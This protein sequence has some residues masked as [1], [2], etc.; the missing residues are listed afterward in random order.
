VILQTPENGILPEGTSGSIRLS[1]SIVG[2]EYWVTR[3]SALFTSEI[4]GTGS[5]LDLGNYYPSGSY[6]VNSRTQHNCSLVQGTVNFTT[7]TGGNTGAGK[8]VANVSFGTPASSFPANHVNVKLYKKEIDINNNEVIIY[9]AQ[10]TLGT[11]GQAEFLN[12]EPGDY[13]MGSFILYP[14][15]YN[16]AEHVYYQTAV[17]HEE[18]ISI[19]VFEETVFIANLHHVLLTESQGS[20]TM[21][22]IVGENNNAKSLNPKKDMVVV[23]KNADIDEIIGVSVTNEEGQYYFEDVPVNA[24][25]QAFVTSF[26]HQN[27]TAFE[28]ETDSYQTYNVN[29]IVSGTSVYPDYTTMIEDVQIQNIE[30]SVFPNPA[31]D[32][33]NINCDIEK[34]I[35]Q[36]FDISG[37]LVKTELAFSNSEINISE[38]VSGTYL[39]ILSAEN[40]KTGIQKFVKE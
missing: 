18:A 31:N 20:N 29:F 37:K 36:I 30:F 21:Q 15:N 34:A 5:M 33:L 24:N 28:I 19:P 38:L 13:Y 11:N 25:I 40:G 3:A 35:V 6:D 17:V 14:D 27:W 26:A 7:G 1:T 8:I 39:I 16:V 32:V 23:L 12:L 9:K 10:Q 4:S 22:G 2:T